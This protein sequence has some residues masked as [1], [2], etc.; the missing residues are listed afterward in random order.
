MIFVT[1]FFRPEIG[2][3]SSRITTLVERMIENNESIFVITT[4]P[5]YKLEKKINFYENKGK[6]K[7]IRFPIFNNNSKNIILRLITM[8]NFSFYIFLMIP[9]IIFLNHKRV[10]IQGHP[11]ISSFFSI[12][13]F[14]KLFSKKIILNV[15]DLW[16]KSGL[17]LGVF[18]RGK[19]YSILKKI[20]RFNYRNSDLI[21][22]QSEES[23]AYISKIFP[24]KNINVFYNVPRSNFYEKHFN[25]K[26]ELKLIYA[27]L[28]GHAQNILK[29]CQAID[30][31]SLNIIFTIYGEGSQ[32]NQIVDYIENNNIQN[33]KVYDFITPKNLNKRL[34]ESD[35]GLVQLKNRIYGALPSKLFHYLNYNLPIIYV[36]EGEASKIINNNSY[37][38][39]FRNNDYVGLN[40]LLNEINSDNKHLTARINSIKN[41]FKKKFDYDSQF[42]MFNSNIKL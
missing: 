32:K 42:E 34:K 12:L 5:S 3:A 9:L 17:E 33:I 20:E 38:W 7:I 27:G 21:I 15:S 29:T 2:A 28:L 36:G 37:G 22:T 31:D 41:N 8:L 25:Q 1:H 39:S 13:I 14:K 26:S 30:F 10:F 23:K 35:I 19:F 6:L 11:L 24:K 18:K 40:K 4:T 16:P